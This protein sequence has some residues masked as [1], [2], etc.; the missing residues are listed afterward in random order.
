MIFNE[1]EMVISI[2]VRSFPEKVTIFITFIEITEII[3]NIPNISDADIADANDINIILENIENASFESI[4]VESALIRRSTRHMKVIFKIMG[5]NA[6]VINVMEV[7][8]A[9]I[10]SADEKE[11]EKEDYL[12]KVMIAKIIIANENKLTYEKTMADSEES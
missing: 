4:I 12:S 2:N 5:A 9:S 3:E 8:E 6:V 7:A 10:I 1:I 11:S